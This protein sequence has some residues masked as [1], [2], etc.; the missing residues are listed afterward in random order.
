MQFNPDNNNPIKNMKKLF[1]KKQGFIQSSTFSLKKLSSGFTLIELLIVIAIIGILSTIVIASVNDAKANARDK[2]RISDLLQIQLA[3]EQFYDENG[4]FPIPSTSFGPAHFSSSAE[5]LLWAPIETALNPY[6]Q[7]PL[8]DPNLFSLPP[9]NAPPVWHWAGP[10][11]MYA[12]WTDSNGNGYAIF[13][14]FEKNNPRDCASQ[15]YTAQFA[16]GNPPGGGGTYYGK[17]DSFCPNG[18]TDFNA[19]LYVVSSN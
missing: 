17:G 18:A 4:S 8:Q 3:L 10:Q 1:Q 13:A 14:M 7:G 12:Y 5:P 15:N 11:R 16:Y 19:R 9:V 6:V 2:Q